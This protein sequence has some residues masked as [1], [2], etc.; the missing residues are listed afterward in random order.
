MKTAQ[1]GSSMF[2]DSGQRRVSDTNVDLPNPLDHAT[3][4]TQMKVEDDL[5]DLDYHRFYH[6]HGYETLEG[7]KHTVEL[8]RDQEFQHVMSQ[9]IFKL[10]KLRGVRAKTISKLS[11]YDDK[12][13]HD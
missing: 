2:G 4:I 6:N 1:F 8:E 10:N 7:N 12:V 9:T 3:M 11:E 5:N 13:T